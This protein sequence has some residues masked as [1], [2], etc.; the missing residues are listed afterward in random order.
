MM[1]MNNCE[2]GIEIGKGKKKLNAYM[3][4]K[5]VLRVFF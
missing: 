4:K 1:H 2:I 5:R 3:K